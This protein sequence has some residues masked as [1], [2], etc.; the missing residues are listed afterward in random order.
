MP[1]QQHVAAGAGGLLGAVWV[2]GQLWAS[3]LLGEGAQGLLEA[4]LL[5]REMAA[6]G[7]G[8]GLQSLHVP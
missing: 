5:G 3:L 1:L 4:I 8:L 2:M 7:E 6:W